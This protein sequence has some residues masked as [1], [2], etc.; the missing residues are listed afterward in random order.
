VDGH[1]HGGGNQ[2]RDLIVQPG[3]VAE[4]RDAFSGALDRV[5]RQIEL[6]GTDLRVAAWAQDPVST[7][8][9]TTFNQR[10][11]DPAGGGDSALD[12]L[13]AYRR[14]LST[15]VDNLAKTA[16]QYALAEEDGSA[17]V[18]TRDEGPGR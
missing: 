2:H 3:A 5:D 12:A 14:Q 18:S 1:A 13:L 17:N 4:L 8:A 15:A 16:Q 7:S 10:S 9:A 6:A 11:I